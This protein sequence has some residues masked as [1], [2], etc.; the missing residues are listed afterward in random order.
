LSGAVGSQSNPSEINSARPAGGD[1]LGENKTP[2]VE[3]RPVNE[4]ARSGGVRMSQEDEF[5]VIARNK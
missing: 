5:S 3:E 1:I 4:S 2:G